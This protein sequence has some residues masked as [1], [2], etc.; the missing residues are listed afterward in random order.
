VQTLSRDGDP[1]RTPDAPR[2]LVLLA[3]NDS[4]L[5]SFLD[6]A[7]AGAGYRVERT[8]KLDHALGS[9]ERVMPDVVLLDPGPGGLEIASQLRARTDVPII[10]LSPFNSLQERVAALDA[11]ADDYLPI[12]FA[13]EEL[14]ARLR[15]VLRGRALAAAGATARARQGTLT[16]NDITMD[17]DTR[18]VR[19]ADRKVELRHKAFEL[20]ACFMRHPNRVLSRRELLEDVWGYDFLGD[21]NVIEVT[22]SNIRQAMEAEG[23][24]RLIFTVRPIGYILT[25]RS[26]S[27]TQSTVTG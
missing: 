21:S 24:P 13:V 14:L 10:V 4:R 11:G 2:P 22:V 9:L 15:A 27:L 25:N 17:L 16:Y 19:R 3:E 18:E 6:R 8:D 1:T 7:L 23:E 20:L 12:P 26:P 5:A